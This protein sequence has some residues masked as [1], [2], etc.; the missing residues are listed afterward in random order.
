MAALDI[1]T[2][3]YDKMGGRCDKLRKVVSPIT[4]QTWH[5]GSAGAEVEPNSAMEKD[6]AQLGRLK[7]G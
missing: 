5:L 2:K 6:S 3:I 1:R 7:G 4:K